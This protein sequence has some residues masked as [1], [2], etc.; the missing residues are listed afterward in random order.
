M[1]SWN[2]ITC[3]DSR[4]SFILLNSSRTFIR[5]SKR[6][7]DV[8]LALLM[9]RMEEAGVPIA[10]TR[11]VKEIYFTVMRSR[12]H[13]D[14]SDDI[15]RLSCA[16]DSLRMFERILLHELAHHLDKIEDLSGHEGILEEKMKRARFMPDRYARSSVD[17]YIA[18]GFETFY[19]GFAEDKKRLRK[20]NPRL[21]ALIQ[22]MHKKYRSR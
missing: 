11:Q 7:A 8:D 5:L 22:K 4:G 16:S 20:H 9:V 2:V 19:F 3:S 21:Y 18:I 6:A 12:V 17:E 13:G 1:D 15:V 10:Y 14:Y